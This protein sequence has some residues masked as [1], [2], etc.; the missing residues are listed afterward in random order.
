VG[1]VWPFG[2]ELWWGFCCVGARRSH[3][4]S[5]FWKRQRFNPKANG[6]IFE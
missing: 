6:V 2:I 1:L 5:A 3:L 4:S